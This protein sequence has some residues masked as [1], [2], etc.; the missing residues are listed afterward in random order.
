MPKGKAFTSAKIQ[1][2]GTIAVTGPFIQG[3]GEA[4]KVALVSFCIAQGSS[5]AYGQGQWLPG[6]TV[7]TGTAEGGVQV[8]PS[9]G[10]AV[11]VSPSADGNGFLTSSWNEPVDVTDG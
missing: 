9:H 10:T 8:G 2:D 11:A 5:T 1:A 4:S 7:W 3:P 6:Q